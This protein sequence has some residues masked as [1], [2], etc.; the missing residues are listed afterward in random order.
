M[1]TQMFFPGDPLL[2]FDPIYNGIPDPAARA[3]LISQFDLELTTPEWALGYRFDIVLAGSLE[4][5]FEPD[6][7]DDEH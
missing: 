2:P 3:R 7:D 4:T 1:V 5:P 6:G